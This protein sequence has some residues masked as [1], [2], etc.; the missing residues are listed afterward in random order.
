MIDHH[1]IEEQL[2]DYATGRASEP[3]GLI[4]A[5]H[6]ALCPAC[7][8][9]VRG[10]EA[11]GGALLND[12]SAA[13]APDIDTRTDH[14]LARV[15][16][17]LDEPEPADAA[18]AARASFDDATRRLV[19]EPLRSALGVDLDAIAW[20]R[21]ARG[22]DEHVLPLDRPGFKTRLLRIRR[23]AAIPRHGHR[24][25]ESVLVLDGGFADETGHYGRGDVGVS[26]EGVVHRPVADEDGDCLCLIVVEGRLRFAGLLGRV[27]WLFGRY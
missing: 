2:L 15:L 20:R 6:L 25:T 5:T 9:Q 11:I 17:R 14:G 27:L 18:P 21:V 10:F 4:V 26:D 16:A 7:R 12:L 13:V 19:P 22:L 8:R 3:V 1:P 23:G 24:G